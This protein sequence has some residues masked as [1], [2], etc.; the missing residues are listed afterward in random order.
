[1]AKKLAYIGKDG[2]V[3]LLGSLDKYDEIIREIIAKKGNAIYYGDW[4]R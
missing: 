4:R 2:K 3:I 1:M